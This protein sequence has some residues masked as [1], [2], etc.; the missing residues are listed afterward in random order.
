VFAGKKGLLNDRNFGIILLIPTFVFIGGVIVFPLINAVYMSFTKSSFINIQLQKYIGL[1]NYEK[2]FVNPTYWKVVK[3]TFILGS[4]SIGV[5]LIIGLGLALALN[6]VGRFQ[7]ILRS[8]YVI[9]WILPAVVIG[10]I[11]LW[12]LSTQVGVVNFILQ[13]TGLIQSNLPWLSDIYLSR[14]AVIIMFIWFQTPFMMVALLA[15]LQTIPQELKEASIVDGAG[16]WQVFRYISLPLL[17]PIIAICVILSMVYFFQNFAII[18]TTTSGGPANATETF[19]LYVYDTAFNYGWVGRSCAIGVTWLLF[20]LVFA[21][22]Y[23]KLGG[24]ERF[25]I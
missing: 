5:S 3:N 23:F 14:A 11:W 2:I 24:R 25:G 18:Y 6:G 12:L 7:R 9:P 20:L 16:R 15:G 1:R 22:F 13:S 19:C 17:S 8:I 10:I 4:I 21:L